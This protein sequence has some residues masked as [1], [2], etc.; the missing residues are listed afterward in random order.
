MAPGAPQAHGPGDAH[1]S[2]PFLFF[3]L[4]GFMDDQ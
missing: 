3:F 4:M 2:F 1:R